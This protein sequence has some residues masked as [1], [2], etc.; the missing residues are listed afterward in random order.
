MLLITLLLFYLVA[1]KQHSIKIEQIVFVIIMFCL[2]SP[3]YLVGPL[4]FTPTYLTDNNGGYWSQFLSIEFANP[5]YCIYALIQNTD[6]SYN[7]YI[8]KY[9]SDS[10]LNSSYDRGNVASAYTSTCILRNAIYHDGKCKA[11]YPSSSGS[12]AYLNFFNGTPTDTDV[13]TAT[14]IN[15][16]IFKSICLTD[17]SCVVVG[18]YTG[19]GFIYRVDA[20]GV[21]TYV[22]EANIP[23]LSVMQYDDTTLYAVILNRPITRN[24]LKRI[25]IRHR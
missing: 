18:D 22:T 20:A 21:G 9:N 6:G 10:S 16:L 19:Y 14:V 3:V 1:L 12:T 23:Y 4:F 8:R 5:G 17:G 24:C 25:T 13:Q 2:V 11:F 7:T 15:L